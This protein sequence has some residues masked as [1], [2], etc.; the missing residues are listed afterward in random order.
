MDVLRG[1]DGR[2]IGPVG[3]LA[4]VLLGVGFL[5]L[6]VANGLAWWEPVLGLIA[7][8]ALLLAGH[9]LRLRRTGAP[10]HATGHA[11]F[12]LNAV[13]LAALLI[14]PT[15]QGATL[16]WLGSSLLLAAWRGYAGCESLAVSNWLLRRNDQVGCLLFSP[17]D[18]AEARLRGTSLRE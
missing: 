7:V 4:R 1:T 11:G 9:A 14:I 2:A 17:L 13:I 18:R 16:L 12:C 5:A 3:A 8:P 6:A 10:L 15:T